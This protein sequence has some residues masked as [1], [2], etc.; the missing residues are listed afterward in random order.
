M[1]EL[2]LLTGPTCPHCGCRDG[3]VIQ[4]PRGMFA[5]G[6]TVCSFCERQFSFNA[7]QVPDPRAHPTSSDEAR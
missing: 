2:N 1:F 3:T 6:V 7:P 4:E 5:S